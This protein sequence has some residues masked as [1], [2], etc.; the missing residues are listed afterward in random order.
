MRSERT[1]FPI[2]KKEDF[3]KHLDRW[4]A[5]TKKGKEHYN[6]H[7]FFVIDDELAFTQIFARGLIDDKAVHS[8]K[9]PEH[10][11]WDSWI[12]QQKESAPPG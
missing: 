2:V 7:A 11:R 1:A 6:N 3:F 9:F 8:I 10:D 12:E 4:V 5:L